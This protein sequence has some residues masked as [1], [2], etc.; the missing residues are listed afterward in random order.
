MKTSCLGPS[1][2]A[3]LPGGS[4]AVPSLGREHGGDSGGAVAAARGGRLRPGALARHLLPQG[5]PTTEVRELIR[6][7]SRVA[8]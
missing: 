2:L 3:C 8:C 6:A 4:P 5:R 1:V 7:A